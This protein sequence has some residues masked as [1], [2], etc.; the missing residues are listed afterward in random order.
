MRVH[1]PLPERVQPPLL[2]RHLRESERAAG[3]RDA[4]ALL[5][6]VDAEPRGEGFHVLGHAGEALGRKVLIEPHAARRRLRMQ[7]ESTPVEL[8]IVFVQQ[9]D[10]T[11][12]LRD[13]A[14]RSDEV[15]VEEKVHGISVPK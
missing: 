10:Q 15:G 9:P 14:E 6:I 4:L 11:A 13:V 3:I 1:R 7:L 12:S 5:K 8:E 2:P